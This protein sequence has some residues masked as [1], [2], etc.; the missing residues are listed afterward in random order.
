MS[1][2]S[3][4]GIKYSQ[5]VHVCEHYM[6]RIDD[7][8]YDSYCATEGSTTPSLI[9]PDGTNVEPASAVIAH[10]LSQ[11]ISTASEEEKSL[12]VWVVKHIIS[13]TNDLKLQCRIEYKCYKV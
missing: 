11:V 7:A 6:Q 12:V 10:S 2:S 3:K 9:Q 1:Q 4:E 5:A 13:S 8:D